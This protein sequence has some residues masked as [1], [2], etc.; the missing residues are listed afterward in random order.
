VGVG[1]AVHG[2]VHGV[3]C[4]EAALGL[5]LPRMAPGLLAGGG[6]AGGDNGSNDK[7]R[8]SGRAGMVWV[9]V[10]VMMQGA[11]AW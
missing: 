9:W 1:L 8:G 11:V 2:S 4:M 6:A 7:V 3:V 10:L 5:V